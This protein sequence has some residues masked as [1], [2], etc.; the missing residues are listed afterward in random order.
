MILA[1]V[2]DS[3]VVVGQVCHEAPVNL[4]EVTRKHCGQ[5]RLALHRGR[6]RGSVH[7]AGRISPRTVLL[8]WSLLCLVHLTRA[9]CWHVGKPPPSME[10]QCFTTYKLRRDTSPDQWSSPY[11][12]VADSVEDFLQSGE[13]K[14]RPSGSCPPPARGTDS[15][16]FGT[17]RSLLSVERELRCG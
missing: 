3:M 4:Q 10:P 6:C 12:K 13:V 9:C 14:S 16:L 5:S 17:L 11:R 2:R 8:N 15:D 7:H 1:V